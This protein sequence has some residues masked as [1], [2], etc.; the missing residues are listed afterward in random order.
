MKNATLG[1]WWARNRNAVV[2]LQAPLGGVL[3]VELDPYPFVTLGKLTEGN[4]RLQQVDATFEL[5]LEP[6]VCTDVAMIQILAVTTTIAA[7][8][9]DVVSLL[10]QVGD[11]LRIRPDLAQFR[12]HCFQPSLQ[13]LEL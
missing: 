4:T 10:N 6:L 13:L 8:I 11:S 9:K 2:G 7:T 5:G 3:E 12:I 1:A